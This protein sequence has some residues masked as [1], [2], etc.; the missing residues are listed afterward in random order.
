[1]PTNMPTYPV[2]RN[3]LLADD[4]TA[5]YARSSRTPLKGTRINSEDAPRHY[6]LCLLMVMKHRNKVLERNCFRHC[7]CLFRIFDDAGY[8]MLQ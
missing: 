2:L 6:N 1:M 8:E 4:F 5:A 7:F 3:G